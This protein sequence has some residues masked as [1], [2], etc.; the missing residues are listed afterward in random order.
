MLWSLSNMFLK[1]ARWARP[2]RSAR[3]IQLASA[4]DMITER[5]AMNNQQLKQTPRLKPSFGLSVVDRDKQSSTKSYTS[6]YG[7][8]IIR[9]YYRRTPR[10]DKA[11]STCGICTRSYAR[12]QSRSN[13]YTGK[14][15]RLCAV[16][17]ILRMPKIASST[18]KHRKTTSLHRNRTEIAR[19]GFSFR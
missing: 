11:E 1:N 19:S 14:P 9:R 17:S 6:E 5:R 8:L 4:S 16:S 18:E 15:T 12:L 2:S 10:R 3:A 7:L 13:R